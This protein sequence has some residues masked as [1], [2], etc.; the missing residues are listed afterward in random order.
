MRILICSNAPWAATG[1]GNQ[2]KLFAQRFRAM[3]H[4][5]AIH[6]FYGLE[7]G[8][9]NWNGIP[10]FPKAYHNFGQDIMGA[11]ARQ[12][13][14]D[15][16]ITLIDAWVMEPQ[17]YGPHVRWCPWFP[18]DMDRIPPPVLGKV[19]EAFQPIVYSQYALRLCNQA[20]LDVRYVPHGVDLNTYKPI[21]QAEARA[22]VSLPAD[23]FI[24]GMIAAN[25]GTP[26]RK[27]L[28]QSIMAFAEYRKRHPDMF[29]YLHTH[30]GTEQGGVN[31]VEL[32]TSLGLVEGQ[33]YLCA[34]AYGL[35][36][37]YP[38]EQMNCIYNSF[39]VLL[40]ASMGEGFG[41]PIL[42]A[43]AAGVP[44][45][46]GDW[47]SMSELTF[48]GINVPLGC[49]E[50]FWTPLGAC[51][52]LPH[53]DALTDAIRVAHKKKLPRE[54]PPEVEQ[55]SADVVADTHWQPTLEEIA[56]RL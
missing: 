55:Y 41:I 10:V 16:V 49:A 48:N 47:T 31:I 37:G 1:Y 30:K 52:Y 54:R 38:D 26:S 56:G 6:A 51:Q 7:G 19:I 25:K 32:C 43:Q 11:H 33:D 35:A 12:F 5:I 39:D 46:T 44:V 28:P 53:I 9:L 45:I 20:G 24:V 22:R 15:I 17:L 42:E 8:V 4:E 2:T 14:A 36:L 23:K 3:G 18:I 21:D 29:L 27:A 40:A 50:K 34:D 13:K